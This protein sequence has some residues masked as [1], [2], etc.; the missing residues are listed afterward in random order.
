MNLLCESVTLNEITPNRE[1]RP[2]IVNDPKSDMEPMR[3][4]PFVSSTSISINVNLLSA[5]VFD[6]ARIHEVL[7]IVMNKLAE[8]EL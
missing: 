3:E 2:V 1:T 4:V 6:E 5:G 8:V 7:A